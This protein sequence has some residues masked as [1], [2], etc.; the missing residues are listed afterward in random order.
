[1][2]SFEDIFADVFKQKWTGSRSQR[3]QL[4]V[5]AARLKDAIEPDRANPRF[6]KS[7]HSQGYWID[8]P[9]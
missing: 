9:E 1:V 4:Q 2:C 3:S 5:A 8:L 6:I 7:E